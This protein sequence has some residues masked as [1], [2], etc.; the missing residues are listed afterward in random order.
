[1]KGRASSKQYFY[2]YFK[3]FPV[4]CESEAGLITRGVNL[5]DCVILL[6][7]IN[8]VRLRYH[9]DPNPGD[10]RCLQLCARF[11]AHLNAYQLT[12]VKQWAVILMD[13]MA[14]RIGRSLSKEDFVHLVL[15]LYEEEVILMEKCKGKLL[16]DAQ[17]CGTLL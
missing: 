4:A 6:L 8:F 10:G 9:A 1:M 12:Q 14:Y 2:T 17:Q 7:L 15:K 3:M 5:R 16:M 13:V 11:L